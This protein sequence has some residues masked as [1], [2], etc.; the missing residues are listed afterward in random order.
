M[1]KENG[2]LDKKLSDLKTRVAALE[3]WKKIS[4]ENLEMKEIEL[5]KTN[6]KNHQLEEELSV[7]EERCKGQRNEAKRL[8]NDLKISKVG[9]LNCH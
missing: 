4:T 5:I 9:F 1:L 2:I 3:D 6:T 7:A 8:A